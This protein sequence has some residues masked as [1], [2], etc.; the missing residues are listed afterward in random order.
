[1][2]RWRAR[3]A[4]VHVVVRQRVE[5]GGLR[6]LANVEKMLESGLDVRACV[7]DHPVSISQSAFYLE[8]GC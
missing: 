6:M 7:I 3:E 2:Y 5:V 4:H 1:M 8:R